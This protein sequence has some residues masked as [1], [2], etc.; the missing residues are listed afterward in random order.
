MGSPYLG[1]GGKEKWKPSGTFVPSI[2]YGK[3]LAQLGM[4]W[5]VFTIWSVGRRKNGDLREPTLQ[6]LT[7]G[8][9][10]HRWLRLASIH[11]L[12]CGEKEEWRPWGTYDPAIVH[13]Q[14][15]TD[16]HRLASIHYIGCAEKEE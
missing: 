2:Y 6:A 10:F 16:D 8:R 13:G 5:P 14:T 3:T 12:E 4:G 1:S 15:S 11:Y 9:L 7:T